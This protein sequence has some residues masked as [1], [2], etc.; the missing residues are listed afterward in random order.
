[1]QGLELCKADNLELLERCLKIRSTV[2]VVEKGVPRELEHDGFDVLNGPCQH[3]LI[4]HHGAD[5]GAL[6]CMQLSQ[7]AVQIQRLCLLK[8][9]RG[10]GLGKAVL[11][12]VEHELQNQGV[13]TLSLDA[14]CEASG[15]YEKCGY[16][17]ASG[18]FMEANVAHVRMVKTLSCEIS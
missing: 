13:S 14:K 1:M 9:Y 8:E 15:F 10:L 6:R 12:L 17:K 2:F 5:V 7:N 11:A 16:Q 3:F 18:V 4:R